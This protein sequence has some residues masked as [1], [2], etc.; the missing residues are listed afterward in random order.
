MLVIERILQKLKKIEE[1]GHLSKDDLSNEVLG[2]D[3]N[4]NIKIKNAVTFKI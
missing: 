1:N 3:K 2:I 4:R